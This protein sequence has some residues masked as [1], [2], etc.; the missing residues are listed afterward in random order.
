MTPMNVWSG[1]EGCA[2]APHR[3]TGAEPAWVAHQIATAAKQC[4]SGPTMCRGTS[5][6]QCATTK[7]V[8]RSLHRACRRAYRFGSTWYRGCCY[9]LRHFPPAVQQKVLAE[10]ST[11]AAMPKPPVHQQY[12]HVA[13]KRLKIITW[14][15]G[16]LSLARFD[17]VRQWLLMQS[18]DVVI[19]AETRWMYTQEWQDQHWNCVHSGDPTNRGSGI[20]C[21]ISRRLLRLQQ[22]RWLDHIPGRLLHIQLQF[23]H[24]SI[25]ILGCY[26]YSNAHTK[27]RQ[28]ERK[29][30][31]SALDQYM[32]TLSRRNLTILA[33]DFNCS[34][35]AM[36][37]HVGTTNFTWK[38]QK[39]ESTDHLD[40]GTFAELI[41]NHGLVA[42]NTW[43]PLQGPTYIKG[44]AMSRIDYILVKRQTADG[45]SRCALHVWD[46]PFLSPTPDGHAPVSAHI[47]YNWHPVADHAGG[48]GI[49]SHQRQRGCDAWTR[50][51]DEWRAFMS[52]S[53][54]AL[55]AQMNQVPASDP[56]AMHRLNDT[57]IACFRQCFQY[58]HSVSHVP[59]WNFENRAKIT[60]WKHRDFLSKTYCPSLP[61]IFRCW[62]HAARYQ[63]L[64]RSHKKYAYQ[65]R[66]L[67][68]REL[69]TEATQAAAVHDSFKLFSVIN[70]HAPKTARRRMQLRNQRGGVATPSE[71]LAILKSYVATKW[72]GPAA[73]TMPHSSPPGVP[74]SANELEH[75]LSLIPCNKAVAFPYAPGITW[76]SHSSLF[77]LYIYQALEEWWHVFPPMIPQEWRD[78]WLILIPKPHKAPTSPKQLRPLAMQHPIGKSIL[79]LL[80]QKAQMQTF[81]VLTCWP[82]WAYLG[83]R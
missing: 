81:A 48:L 62:H 46:A 13:N 22:I 50:D 73:L 38:G 63:S 61:N 7:V 34:I 32:Q 43:D 3:S 41:R 19:I 77:A 24:R 2:P 9:Q 45:L 23:K 18:A 26:Q 58:M 29:Q 79:G 12:I 60:K 76:R 66:L 31:W 14:N 51:T 57:L 75:A 8:K 82:L 37:G 27:Q 30:W 65:N 83:G 21:L 69:V 36:R 55:T 40:K 47:P 70:K 56:Q 11:T 74:F 15:P 78:G 17:E 68:F 44:E 42:I 39:R 4:G 1:G 67:R 6:R 49:T 33:G 16:G 71:E 54:A 53:S 52:T 80:T 59:A 25:D 5:T 35:D 28:L 72:Q 20:M 64:Q 10:D